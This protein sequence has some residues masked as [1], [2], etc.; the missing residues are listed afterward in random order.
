[1]KHSKAHCLCGSVQM[2]LSLKS[3]DIHACHCQQC[4]RWTGGGPLF[5]A[6]VDNLSI[7]GREHIGSYHASEHGERGFCQRCGTTLYWAMRGSDPKFVPVGLL[8]DQTNLKVSEEIFVDHRP[9]W[10]PEFEGASQSTESQEL[11]QLQKYLAE[12]KA[13]ANQ[14]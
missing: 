2:T 11:Q 13:S 9:S 14:D 1:M 7:S 5:V 3:Q 12:K 10:L 4:Q 8:E 6:P